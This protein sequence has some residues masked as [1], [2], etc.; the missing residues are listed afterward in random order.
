MAALLDTPVLDY[1]LVNKKLNITLSVVRAL[2]EQ[3]VLALETEQVYRNPVK[4]NAERKKSL[5]TEEQKHAIT[6]FRQDYE[7]RTIKPICCTV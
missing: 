7:N 4:G 1:D 3:Q 6:L 5:L 2:E